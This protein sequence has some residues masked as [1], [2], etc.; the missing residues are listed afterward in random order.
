MSASKRYSFARMEIYKGIVLMCVFVAKM[1]KFYPYTCLSTAIFHVDNLQYKTSFTSQIVPS[2]FQANM[3]SLVVRADRGEE[4]AG[5]SGTRI[6]N[7]VGP[8]A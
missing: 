5:L 6:L 2:A 3:V 4:S 1:C 8:K 7:T